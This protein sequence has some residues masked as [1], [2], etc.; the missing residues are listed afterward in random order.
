MNDIAQALEKIVC[1]VPER[2]SKVSE[3]ESS[4]RP[5]PGKWSK[6]EI[7]GH[8]IDSAS[9][10]HQRFVRAQESA[11]LEFPGYTQNLW[12]EAQQYRSEPWNSLVSLW[13]SFNAHL[14]HLVS[15]IPPSHWNKECKI[16]NNKPV[17]L[18]FLAEDYV[19]H[20]EH[21]LQQILDEQATARR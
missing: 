5:S 15:N 6:K 13:A 21:H 1:E 18:R 3:F 19:R 20:M 8:L 17:T 12:V 11:S 7:L 2:L 10:N 14:A 9:N 16:G 4:A